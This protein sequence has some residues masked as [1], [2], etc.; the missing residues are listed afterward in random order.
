MWIGAVVSG[1]ADL[2]SAPVLLAGPA[3]HECQHISPADPFEFVRRPFA[4][5]MSKRKC[6]RPPGPR[7]TPI[8]RVPRRGALES[9]ADHP[10]TE[11]GVGVRVLVRAGSEKCR[12]VQ[13]SRMT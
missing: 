8:P 4:P 3:L 2:G 11:R 13:A 6:Q 7:T 10:W 1:D 5:W 9:A 12:D